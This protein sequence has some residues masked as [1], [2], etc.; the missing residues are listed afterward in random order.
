MNNVI[1]HPIFPDVVELALR[2]LALEPFVLD[3]LVKRTVGGSFLPCTSS[4]NL[5]LDEVRRLDFASTLLTEEP[6]LAKRFALAPVT[7]PSTGGGD[8][9]DRG[10]LSTELSD[11]F[12]DSVLVK[13]FFKDTQQGSTSTHLQNFFPHRFRLESPQAVAFQR[14][15]QEG[16]SS[17]DN[18]SAKKQQLAFAVKT[19]F[20]SDEYFRKLSPKDASKRKFEN[21]FLRMSVGKTERRALEKRDR[22]EQKYDAEELQ[23]IQRNRE[24]VDLFQAFAREKRRKTLSGELRGSIFDGLSSSSKDLER[25]VFPPRD[26]IGRLALEAGIGYDSFMRRSG[27][28]AQASNKPAGL[29]LEQA[30]KKRTDVLKQRTV[31]RDALRSAREL[32]GGGEQEDTCWSSYTQ[33]EHHSNQDPGFFL[34]LMRWCSTLLFQHAV[35]YR[36]PESHCVRT[37]DKTWLLYAPGLLS[38][39]S[40]VALPEGGLEGAG[41]LDEVQH[42]SSHNQHLI[43]AL[44]LARWVQAMILDPAVVGEGSECRVSVKVLNPNV[45]EVEVRRSSS[46]VLAGAKKAWASVS[47]DQVD[48][49]KI[50]VAQHIRSAAG[51][52]DEKAQK[53]A[54][55][56]TSGSLSE[57]ISQEGAGPGEYNAEAE[58]FLGLQGII[59]EGMPAFLGG[60]TSSPV[61]GDRLVYEFDL[62]DGGVTPH[63]VDEKNMPEVGDAEDHDS[64]ISTPAVTEDAIV[65]VDD[66]VLASALRRMLSDSDPAI[67][68]AGFDVLDAAIARSSSIAGAVSPDLVAV[69][70][71]RQ[72]ETEEVYFNVSRLLKAESSVFDAKKADIP[73]SVFQHLLFRKFGK[74]SVGESL[75]SRMTCA[76]QAEQLQ[77]IVLGGLELGKFGIDGDRMHAQASLFLSMVEV[78]IG[79]LSGVEFNITFES[80]SPRLFSLETAHLA[81]GVLLPLPGK[82][83]DVVLVN[84]LN[85]L[86]ARRGLVEVVQ[87][88]ASLW[89]NVQRVLNIL[90]KGEREN[91]LQEPIVSQLLVVL[92]ESVRAWWEAVE[93]QKVEKQRGFLTRM[94][95]SSRAG[96]TH[97]TEDACRQHER[98]VRDVVGLLRQE[99][100][101]INKTKRV[102]GNGMNVDDPAADTEYLVSDDFAKGLVPV[103]EWVLKRTARSGSPTKPTKDE[104]LVIGTVRAALLSDEGDPG[105]G[106]SEAS[107]DSNRTGLFT[108]LERVRGRALPA[109]VEPIVA[110]LLSG[111]TSQKLRKTVQSS[112]RAVLEAGPQQKALSET[113]IDSFVQQIS[114]PKFAEHLDRTTIEERGIA[115]EDEIFPTTLDQAA[116]VVAHI[117][118]KTSASMC[119][120][121]GEL[122]QLLE[123]AILELFFEKTDLSASPADDVVRLTRNKHDKLVDHYVLILSS[124]VACVKE[125]GHRYR[126]DDSAVCVKGVVSPRSEKFNVEKMKAEGSIV[127]GRR[128]GPINFFV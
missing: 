19:V 116:F 99:L 124:Y 72:H 12:S 6:A 113:I 114:V 83:V 120:D 75:L 55:P 107:G 61:D 1:H 13:R 84:I 118:L 104:A 115:G 24:L 125:I 14:L 78:R 70:P 81:P 52:A 40:G 110:A 5:M 45:A 57:D 56:S 92:L 48:V 73:A 35:V 23:L 11:K 54:S 42:W 65:G 2:L 121:H 3:Y 88:R 87:E 21:T 89:E 46:C 33:Q 38:R 109:S 127:S 105:S 112:Y 34:D 32:S 101:Q 62:V 119:V 123:K 102:V 71:Q 60:T 16:L 94:V 90:Q 68:Q 31:V 17:S 37:S 49:N 91:H 30:S 36:S 126:M 53:T 95:Q 64:T 29:L 80:I 93:N 8:L 26:S 20:K 28:L 111:E 106:S 50:I 96:G 47:A 41:S 67:N 39:E 82:I 100:L 108:L 18:L 86:W 128:N 25:L 9:V 59:A 15:L 51:K 74:T 27:N 43:R 77:R 58:L 103:A 79:E 122:R 76:H 117:I 66:F 10:S 44:L 85:V 63:V 4:L 98:I 97:A 7:S 69:H 22:E